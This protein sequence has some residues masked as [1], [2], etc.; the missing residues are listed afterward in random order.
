MYDATGIKSYFQFQN[1]D[2]HSIWSATGETIWMTSIAGI[3]VIILGIILGL[4]LFETRD[5]PNFLVKLINW[6][7]SILVNVFR[8]IPFIILIVLLLP[9]TKDII[10]TI[11]GPKAAIPSLVISA[12]PF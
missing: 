8:S 7:V 9:M 4:L 12:A 5:S 11:I 6:L 3:F 10:G 2:W 1:V